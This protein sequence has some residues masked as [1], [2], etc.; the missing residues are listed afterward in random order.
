LKPGSTPNVVVD[1]VGWT[2][3]SEGEAMT[4]IGM[5]QNARRALVAITIAVAMFV[6][7]AA[8]ASAGTP[9]SPPASCVGTITAYEASQL[10]PGSVGGEVSGLAQSGPGAA[11]AIVSPLAHRHG[12]IEACTQ[13][14]G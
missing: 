9:A 7:S 10:A 14:E 2:T 4:V 1:T 6:A 3:T 5:A 8:P 11:G 13:G 12:S